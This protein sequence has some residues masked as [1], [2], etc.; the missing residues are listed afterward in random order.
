MTR[1][2]IVIGAGGHG[3]VVADALLRAGEPVAGFVDSDAAKHGRSIAGL[4]V[5]GGDDYLDTVAA[6]GCLLANGIG[7]V[8]STAQ[9]RDVYQRMQVRG[10]RFTAVFHPA[11]V[12][13]RHVELDEG[14]QIMAG[15]IVQPGA[16][17]GANTIVNTGAIVDHDCRIG[18]HCHLAPGCVLSGAVE[19]GDQCHVGTGACIRQGIVLGPKTL[20]AAG[21]VAVVDDAGDATL[22]GVPARRRE[23]R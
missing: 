1:A 12:V 3:R 18:A 16:R 7:S 14:V 8:S 20:L 21:A 5:L 19:L 2:I 23:A 9:R 10:F 6:R 22:I 4:P 13:A 17:I 15:A 11:A